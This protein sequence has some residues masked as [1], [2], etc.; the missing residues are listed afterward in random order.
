MNA[1]ASSKEEYMGL[2]EEVKKPIIFKPNILIEESKYDY[3]NGIDTILQ[4]ALEY[5]KSRN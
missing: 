5:T 3:L 4:C 2:P 1:D